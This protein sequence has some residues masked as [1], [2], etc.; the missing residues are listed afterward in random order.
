MLLNPLKE[1]GAGFTHNLEQMFKDIDLAKDVMASFKNTRAGHGK[2]GLDLFVNVLSAS[3]WPS[4]PDVAVNLPTEIGGY[5]SAYEE[6]YRM[7]HSGRKLAWKHSLAQSVVKAAFPKGGNK[8]LS[9][10]SFQA[11]VLLLFNDVEEDA[12]LTYQQIKTASGLCKF[13]CE[14]WKIQHSPLMISSRPRA[15]TNSAVSRLRQ[16]SCSH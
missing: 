7:K 12:A 6:H 16:D 2:D 5:L 1:C 3:A 14:F 8:E 4:Y 13:L 15:Q 11:I 9:V 10:S